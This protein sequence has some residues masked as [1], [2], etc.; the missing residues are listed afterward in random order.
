MPQPQLL[1]DLLPVLW[2]VLHYA[3]KKMKCAQSAA[4]ASASQKYRSENVFHKLVAYAIAPSLRSAPQLLP[5]PKAVE[6]ALAA[7]Y[8]I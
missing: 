5:T 3:H 4:C 1:S 2:H 6:T 7:R 8:G